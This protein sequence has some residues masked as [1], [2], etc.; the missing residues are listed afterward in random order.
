METM[1]KGCEIRAATCCVEDRPAFLR[2]LQT[3]ASENSCHIICF[4]ADMLAGTAHARS[5]VRHA[6]RSFKEGF[7]ISNSLEMEA[8]LYASGSRQCAVAGS[9]GVHEG[10]NNIY[11]CCYPQRKDIWDSL[12]QFHFVDDNWEQLDA[13]KRDRLI[14][15]F[16]ITQDEIQTLG[17]GCRIADLVIER[18]ALLQVS[19]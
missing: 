18:V 3:I 16:D 1:H 10:D 9:F 2:N 14:R 12:D 19:R 8:L 13:E 11:V 15:L 5:A 17:D 7:S 6:V 4:N